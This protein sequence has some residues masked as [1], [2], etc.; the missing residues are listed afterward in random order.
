MNF[1]LLT[2]PA[3]AGNSFYQKPITKSTRFFIFFV[4]FSNNQPAQT[5]LLKKYAR[6]KRTGK[7]ADTCW[8]CLLLTEIG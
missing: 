2:C 1:R 3:E 5:S 7:K 8:R 6:N 4:S